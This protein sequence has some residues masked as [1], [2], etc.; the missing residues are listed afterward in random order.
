MS[1]QELSKTSHV[2]FLLLITLAK[3]EDTEIGL[4]SLGLNDDLFLNFE[5]SFQNRCLLYLKKLNSLIIRL[6]SIL[7]SRRNLRKSSSSCCLTIP[8]EFFRFDSTN[9]TF[10]LISFNFSSQ[11]AL[12][13]DIFLIE[14][15]LLVD[16][17]AVLAARISVP[18]NSV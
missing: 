16:F 1:S 9:F 13:V 15:E 6:F 3:H 5:I 14:E 8:T 11:F 18:H 2:S 10:R 7:R 12:F 17:S 4:K